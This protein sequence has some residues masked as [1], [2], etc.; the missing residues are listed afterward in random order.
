MAFSRDESWVWDF[1]LADD[2]DQFHLYYLFAPKALVDPQLRHRNARIGHATSADLTDWL[3]HGEVLLPGAA[4]DFDETATWTGSVVQ[5][6]DGEWRMFYTGS[7]FHSAEGLSNI[8][9]IG[10][11]T[12]ADLFSW[13]K[14]ADLT[15]RADPR[16]YETFGD[17]DWPEEAWR[18]PWVF[19]DPAGDGWHMLITARSRAGALQERGVIGHAHSADLDSWLVRPPLTPL[20]TGFAHLEVPQLVELDGRHLLIFSAS[21]EALSETDSRLGG[22]WLLDD[23]PPLGPYPVREASL[24]TDQRL[25]GG[26]VIRDRGGNAALLAFELG[27]GENDFAGRISD[28]IPLRRAADG[29]LA[30][31]TE[32][33]A[34]QA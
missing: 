25:Y 27:V 31:G 34:A 11:A 5:G 20:T 22:T 24:L 14:R 10:V 17:S 29:R 13:S 33:N 28:P 8:E 9:S 16:W 1:W 26:K 7:V 19:R 15:L 12:S 18:D 23:V 2:G 3:D 4:G 30:L 6:D 32:S 21:T